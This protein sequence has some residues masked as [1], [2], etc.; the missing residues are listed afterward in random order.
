VRPTFDFAAA[1]LEP[2]P[3]RAAAFF[4]AADAWH[5]TLAHQ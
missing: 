2:G 1:F 5:S 3:L 4:S